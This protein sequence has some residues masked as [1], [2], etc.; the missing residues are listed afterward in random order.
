MAF[1]KALSQM[2]LSNGAPICR[3]NGEPLPVL[4]QIP[5]RNAQTRVR[6]QFLF[7]ELGGKPKVS[8]RDVGPTRQ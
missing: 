6:F 1:F 4:E 3:K 7:R 2:L 5:N 8:R